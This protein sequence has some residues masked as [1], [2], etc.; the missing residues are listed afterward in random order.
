MADA[1]LDWAYHSNQTLPGMAVA[2]L[3]TTNR[4]LASSAV[5]GFGLC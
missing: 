5:G 2:S 1:L 3:V 4:Q